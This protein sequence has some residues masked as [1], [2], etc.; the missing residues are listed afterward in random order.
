MS[1]RIRSKGL[2]MLVV[3][4]IAG[5]ATLNVVSTTFA[6]SAE[7]GRVGIVKDLVGTSWMYGGLWSA[8][9]PDPTNPATIRLRFPSD[10][11]VEVAGP[12][13]SEMG[14][15]QDVKSTE[16]FGAP[17]VLVGTFPSGP[18]AAKC[19]GS[20]RQ[21]IVGDLIRSGI[22]GSS[23]SMRVMFRSAGHTFFED[24]ETGV[25]PL[26]KTSWDVESVD[27]Q[28]IAPLHWSIEFGESGVVGG[29]DGCNGFN[30]FYL[31]DADLLRTS[32]LTSTAIGCRYNSPL[33]RPFTK[34][35]NARFALTAEQLTISENGGHIFVFRPKSF[36]L[37]LAGTTWKSTVRGQRVSLTFLPE[38]RV[39][40]VTPCSSIETT[41]TQQRLRVGGMQYLFAFDRSSLGLLGEKR[42]CRI[43]NE[44]I[45]TLRN[46][47]MRTQDSLVL[48]LGGDD[49][50]VDRFAPRII[51]E[52]D[53]PIDPSKE[54]V[55]TRWRLDTFSPGVAN[56]IGFRTNG[57]FTFDKQCGLW[58]YRVVG[59][60]RLDMQQ[61]TM[62][63]Q[64]NSLYP[65]SNPA[66]RFA[67]STDR[68]T[69]ELFNV[70]DRSIAQYKLV[71]R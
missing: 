32:A 17:F 7:N 59:G 64:R 33:P 57:N 37:P 56:Q 11:K 4:S 31:T 15:L 9:R 1:H 2:A 55:G 40:I 49:S 71:D 28:A 12:C 42:K 44:L 70:A 39:Q 26:A 20:P 23:S 48:Q 46:V 60:T 19:P 67:L 36:G 43:G 18:A 65:F 25:A 29:S 24:T 38:L 8:T 50:T 63:R 13:G 53:T 58:I 16:S 14:E 62:C 41:F 22:N 61:K 30:G 45:N 52:I 47:S 3:G 5:V 69:L 35:G 27:G 66:A 68:K 10:G 21:G 51:F 6:Q 54:L 34:I